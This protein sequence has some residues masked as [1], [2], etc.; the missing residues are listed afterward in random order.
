[1]YATLWGNPRPAAVPWFPLHKVSGCQLTLLPNGLTWD[2]V[3]RG[4]AFIS[5]CCCTVIFLPLFLRFLWHLSILSLCLLCSQLEHMVHAS[6]QACRMVPNFL[7]AC[8]PTW[9]LINGRIRMTYTQRPMHA[10]YNLWEAYEICLVDPLCAR[11]PAHTF[12]GHGSRLEIR[13]LYLVEH[14]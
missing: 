12:S 13:G 4:R 6:T 1:M 10:L 3:Y 9:W 2:Q 8:L 14:F 5:L 7:F 11:W